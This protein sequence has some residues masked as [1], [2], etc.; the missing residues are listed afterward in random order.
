MCLLL[1]LP[2][3]FPPHEGLLVQPKTNTQRM[4]N[5]KTS[6]HQITSNIKYQ[7]SVL[8]F[9][10]AFIIF[11]VSCS[12]YFQCCFVDVLNFP[13]FQCLATTTTPNE[14]KTPNEHYFMFAIFLL[15]F[16]CSPFSLGQFPSLLK[17]MLYLFQVLPQ[18]SPLLT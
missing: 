6:K 17:K 1:S 2:S 7:F 3:L 10:E 11:R 15:P 13:S 16:F 4:I 12:L 18:T 8:Y 5:I 9:K 14:N